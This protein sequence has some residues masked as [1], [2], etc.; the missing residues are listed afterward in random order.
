MALVHEQLH[1]SGDLSRIQFREYVRNLTASLVSSYGIDSSSINLRLQVEDA[2]FPIDIAVPCGLIIQELVSNSLKHAFPS[3]RPGEI[4]VRLRSTPQDMW[5]LTIG[6]NGVGLPEPLDLEHSSSLG[7]R[8][9]RILAEQ[10]DA[11]V[12]CTS[13]AGTRFRVKFRK[14]SCQNE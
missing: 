11:S 8:L 10:I 2:C 1:R 4:F 12:S 9:V 6:D 7:L 14:A 13:G 3:G 5:R